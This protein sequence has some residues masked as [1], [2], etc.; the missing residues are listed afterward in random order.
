MHWFSFGF[1]EKYQTEWS[2]NKMEWKSCA[3]ALNEIQNWDLN[4]NHDKSICSMLIFEKFGIAVVVLTMTNGST[5]IVLIV[6][7]IHS[8]V[9]FC[10]TVKM[11]FISFCFA[12]SIFGWHF[13]QYFLL[14]FPPLRHFLRLYYF[15]FHCD[16]CETRFL[17]L[18]FP[19]IWKFRNELFSFC[20]N[21]CW[22]KIHSK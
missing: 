9:I 8:I 22:F 20:P 21:F 19:F 10:N 5:D 18:F 1:I 16:N 3:T 13:C 6:K 7:L 12:E 2:D 4:L 15:S 17:F 11:L 14:R